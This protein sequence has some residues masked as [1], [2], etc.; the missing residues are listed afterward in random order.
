MRVFVTGA[1]GYVGAHLV[2][3]LLEAGHEVVA[4]S[5]RPV[6]GCPWGDQPAL[7]WVVAD[8]F[9]AAAIEAAL[10]GI[11]ACVHAAFVWG[12]PADDL[13]FRDTAATARLFDAAGRAGVERAILVSSAAVHRPFC[14]GM[15]EADP[16]RTADVYGATKAASELALWAACAGHGMRG[17]VL[18]PGPVVGP[19]AWPEGPFRS[20]A[21]IETIA[22][23][24]R[25]GAPISVRGAEGRQLVSTGDVSQAVV[26]LLARSLVEGPLICVDRGVTP[27]A[28]VATAAVAQ[29]DSASV[30]QVEPG[31]LPAEV[32]WFDNARMV[33]ALGFEPDSRSALHDHLACL[34]A[35]PTG[36]PTPTDT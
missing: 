14:V 30:I 29:A 8:L 28:A 32:P 34:L 5:R 31:P 12:D 15:T 27:W 9:D 24:A 33:S 4:L 26:R 20:P 7:S 19:P 3:H 18:R 10:V 16:L 2:W 21:A 1:A 17:A 35:D 13:N 23:A 25:R 6:V 36:C 22:D 11:E